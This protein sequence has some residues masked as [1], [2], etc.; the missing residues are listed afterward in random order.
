[1][2]LSKL[3]A[4]QY[5]TGQVN[6]LSQVG[7]RAAKL[8]PSEA[9]RKAAT[10][11]AKAYRAAQPF[12]HI[13]LDGLWDEEV[14]DRIEAEFPSSDRGDWLKW[15]TEN[16]LKQTSRGISG[17]EPFSTLVFELMN[18]GAFIDAVK[19]ITGIGDLLP[20]PTFFGAGLHESGPG[21]RLDIHSDYEKH[22]ELPLARR[23]NVLVYLNRN[24]RPEWKGDL[25]L[26]DPDTRTRAVSIAPLFNRTVI[27][28][29]TERAL[30]GF[31]EPITCP[32][33][34]NRRLMSVYYWS[35][36]STLRENAASIRW[37][38]PK[39]RKMGWRDFAPPVAIR[40]V[41]R[42]LGRY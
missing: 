27:F 42:M 39:T 19:A 18:S 7:V 13:V 35:A 28:D 33:G 9:L 5:E 34:R 41:K 38:Q 8:V 30:H 14:L 21:G 22:P 31:P 16:E 23:V 26:W 6:S 10:S 36:N 29:T 25:E 32:P 4:A 17:L 37:A 3:G 24:W 20:D 40:A 1:L 11:M 12:P 2:E 15:D